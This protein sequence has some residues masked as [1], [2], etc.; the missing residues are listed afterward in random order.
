MVPIQFQDGSVSWLPESA[1]EEVPKVP[2]PLCQRFAEGR[3]AGPEWLRRT[4]ARLRVTGREI[5]EIAHV[6]RDA[7]RAR[8][9]RPSLEKELIDAGAVP[10]HR[11]G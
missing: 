2:A 8:I 11:I 7:E 9:A 3:F 4:L 5:G 6:G 1:L 10:S